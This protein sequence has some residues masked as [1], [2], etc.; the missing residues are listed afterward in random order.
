MQAAP[1]SYT[2]RLQV[3]HKLLEAKL[4]EE[5]GE[6]ASA[7]GKQEVSHEA[8]D[9]MYFAMVA[10]HRAGVRLEDVARILDQ[11]ALRITR[12]KGDAKPERMEAR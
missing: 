10:M 7:R 2:S 8:A 9:L 1:G 11:R 5:A 3:D 12:R 6:L 4:P